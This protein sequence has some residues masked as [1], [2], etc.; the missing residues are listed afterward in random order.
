MHTRESIEKT[1]FKILTEH[2][3]ARG[4]INPSDSLIDD[5]GADSLDMVELTMSFEEA[6]NVNFDDNELESIVT[7]KQVVDYICQKVIP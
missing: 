7:V 3:G 4:L 6:F 1:V 5:L 2:L